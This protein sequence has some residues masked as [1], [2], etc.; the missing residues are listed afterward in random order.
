VDS[1]QPVSSGNGGYAS[2]ITPPSVAP[3][4]AGRPGATSAGQTAAQIGGSSLTITASTTNVAM[5]HAQVDSMLNSVG[6]DIGDNQ[7]LRMIIALMI[8]EA[9]LAQDGGNQQAGGLGLFAGM[10]QQRADASYLSIQS[11][12]STIQIQQQSSSLVTSQGIQALGLP[13]GQSEAGGSQ[14]DLQA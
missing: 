7:V 9:L 13:G 5:V 11:E 14:L 12:T 1:I 10:D 4:G 2:R 8:M 6:L 3:T